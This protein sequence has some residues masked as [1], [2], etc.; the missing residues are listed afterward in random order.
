MSNNQLKTTL[1]SYQRDVI[2]RVKG[3]NGR[4]LMAMSMGTGKAEP[5]TAN[6]LT[7]SGW[8][9]MQ[10]LQIGDRVCSDDGKFYPI[11]GKYPQGIKPFYRVVFDD[12]S[13]V[14]V[15]EEHLWAVTDPDNPGKYVVR[16]TKDLYES[17]VTDQEGRCIYQ[18]PVVKPVQFPKRKLG[19]DAYLVGASLS[20]KE[21]VRQ[22]K[23]VPIIPKDCLFSS[24]SDRIKL[25]NALMDMD[26]CYEPQTR[27]PGVYTVSYQRKHEIEHLVRS[28]GGRVYTRKRGEFEP[29]LPDDGF[30]LLID[31]P[32]NIQ[33]F[34]VSTKQTLLDKDAAEPTLAIAK[35]ERTEDMDCC[36]IEIDSPSHLYVTGPFVVTHNTICAATYIM[37]TKSFPA[38]VVCPASLKFNWAE[39][40]KKHFGKR[41]HI[42]SGTNPAK[43]GPL[44]RNGEK[45]Y[46][47][48]YDVLYAWIPTL[49][50]LDPA[51][52]VC[53]ESHY[54]KT[55]GTKRTKAVA[56]IAFNADK[57][58]A[59]T[60]TPITSSPLELYT[61]LN[62][63]FKGHI[64]SKWEFMDR[65]AKWYRGR[66]GIKITGTKNER[67]LNTFLRNRCMIRYKTE[68]V[69]PDLPP[70]IRQTTLLEMTRTQRQEYAR[71]KEDFLTWL[72]ERHPNRKVPRSETS[73]LLT[74]FGYLKRQVAEWKI[75]A[76][77]EN[78]QTFLDGNDG[79][80]IVFGLHKKVLHAI[81]AAFEKKNKKTKPFIVTLDGSTSLPGRASAVK[82]FQ[83]T[84]E[85]RIFLGQMQAAGVGLTLTASNHSLFSELDFSPIA[86]EQAERRNLRIG[87]VAN[88][89]H[90]NYLLMADT[91]EEHVC[92]L[93]F[94]KSQTIARVIDG[95]GPVAQGA[96]MAG[97]FNLVSDL[98]RSHF[99]KFRMECA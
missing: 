76:I 8:K 99:D 59:L 1:F 5:Y 71:L 82:H 67:E 10:D 25:L 94:K 62:M 79:K 87:T 31:L 51:I 45:I 91:I 72:T 12:L 17:G 35:I 93:L 98:L 73:A 52:I 36:C 33:P 77:I 28:L 32:S 97:S 26:G 96:N 6:I 19:V 61:T 70:F 78:I 37:E 75:P 60:G 85:T 81:Y 39:E 40:F 46:V 88:F 24:V 53:D 16:A 92:D 42:L 50:L 95:Q 74:Q 69:L 22:H 55:T 68:D 83:E 27:K 90:Y 3:F 44:L 21:A 30:L 54:I 34:F 43:D 84:P 18:I 11:I 49:K 47:I 57:F 48:N 38:L 58:L 80:L 63:I 64:V 2:E 89:V 86:H 7:E 13:M 29:N 23:P 4:C 15:A 41:V 14:M 9:T 56:Q 66:F 65:Y 20:E